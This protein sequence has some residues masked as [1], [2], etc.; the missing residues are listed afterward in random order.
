VSDTAANVVKYLA[1]LQTQATA[2]RITSIAFTDST[3][4]TLSLTGAQLTADATVL[5]KIT[6][7]YNLSVT[8]GGTEI[9]PT[10][11][12][13]KTITLQP[14]A[15][16]YNFTANS[17]P[18]VTIIDNGTRGGD[19]IKAIAG[20]TV[21]VGG[22]GQFGNT[23]AIT[24]SGGK[25]TLQNNARADIYGG[26]NTVTVGQNDLVGLQNG[27]NN[28]LTVGT[29]SAVYINSGTGDVINAANGGVA[30]YA[31]SGV[32]MGIVGGNNVVV[33]ANGDTVN[34]SG[35][36]QYGN[37]DYITVN[38]GTVNVAA[39]ARADIYGGSDTVV[40]GANTLIGIQGG[41]G[42]KVTLGANS[43][44]YVNSGT[45]DVINGN[46][47]EQYNFAAAFGQDTINNG[48]SPSAN[49]T[50]GF[51]S[52]ITDETLWFLKSGNDLLIDHLGTTGQVKVAGWYSAAG[53]QVQAID[54]GGLILD[55]Q[56]AQLVQ[57]MASYGAT[58][59]GFNPVTATAMPTDTTL[60]N[61][62]AAAW[63]T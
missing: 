6:S 30:V 50:I 52:G 38:S 58:H 9:L 54:A 35:N 32:S 28:T 61:A 5:G 24:L 40:A 56:V 37:S 19:A 59:T 13:A 10:G 2:G 63:H 17:T 29:G 26:S 57:A 55:K 25:V 3:T 1:Q 53:D 20:D 41:N 14:A 43:A 7:A 48:T 12:T 34:V 46:G 16:A 31:S 33:A 18:G 21:T 47:N 51:G 23:D 4:P 11:I 22:N 8:G 27:N 60:Q 62:I 49:G 15:T 44:V 39:N 45:S 42:D 36:G